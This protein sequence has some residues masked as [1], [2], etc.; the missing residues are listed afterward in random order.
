[1]LEWKKYPEF[2]EISKKMLGIRAKILLKFNHLIIVEASSSSLFE[3]P[4]S[5]ALLK[6]LMTLEE[7]NKRW[8]Q[9]CTTSGNSASQHS[10]SLDRSKSSRSQGTLFHYVLKKID[11][12]L[13]VVQA[14]RNW[15]K[16]R[17]EMKNNDRPFTI[18]FIGEGATDGGGPCI[19]SLFF[20]F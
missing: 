14:W 11:A 12:E 17:W 9:I 4:T 3:D 2:A 1:L 20:F 8:H 13:L 10:L 19:F 16:F 5:S 6:R 15:R 7:K 18:N